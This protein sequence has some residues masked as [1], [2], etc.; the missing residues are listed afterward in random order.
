MLNP[1]KVFPYGC[2]GDYTSRCHSC[3]QLGFPL[4]AMQRYKEFLK[5]PNFLF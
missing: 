4:I 1:L 5:C 2:D 3:P